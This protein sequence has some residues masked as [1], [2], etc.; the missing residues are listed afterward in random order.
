MI[1]R[2]QQEALV[3]LYAA[4]R[5]PELEKLATSE[6]RETVEFPAPLGPDD[7]SYH[8]LLT[9]L[10]PQEAP[11]ALWARLADTL[12]AY[13]LARAQRALAQRS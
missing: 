1:E 7:I 11:S 8:F 6:F 4:N 12:E 2:Q 3:K 5:T 10:L 9:E 13:F